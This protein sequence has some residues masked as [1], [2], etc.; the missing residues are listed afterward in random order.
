MKKN[1]YLY[2]DDE[3]NCKTLT[4]GFNDAGIIEVEQLQMERQMTI[5][6]VLSII[7]AC[8]DNFDG[9]IFDLRL[10]GDGANRIEYS[11]STIAQSLRTLCVETGMRDKPF[12]LC[13]TDEKLMGVN[14][15]DSTSRDLY[16]EVFSKNFDIDVEVTSSHLHCLAESYKWLA[17]NSFSPL[18]ILNRTVIEDASLID[19]IEGCT[20]RP[21]AIIRFLLKEL[22]GHPGL[23]I[24]KYILAARLGIDLDKSGQ[25]FNSLSDLLYNDFGYKG[26]L[27][28]YNR[29]FWS[30]DV[31]R[32]FEKASGNR[33]LPMMPAENRVAIVCK[34]TG[35]EGLVSAK[36]IAHDSS[37]LYWSVC[38]ATHQ[39]LDPMEA[40][41]ILEDSSL[42]SWQEPRYISFS[43]LVEHKMDSKVKL[44]SSEKERF[45]LR[46]EEFNAH[47]EDG[48][49]R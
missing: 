10:N 26:V 38:E 8:W 2:I 31:I 7:R 21:N 17:D 37:T 19:A 4:D 28:D 13:S 3:E 14:S 22:F 44:S 33:S 16:D 48:E 20:S 49:E 39:P 23:L 29:Y 9:F 34:T 24:D 45:E 40:F 30:S 1:K 6:S 27:C 42:N 11:A 18:Q 32:W 15:K 46:V 43:S 41:A 12:V 25:A 36:P 47:T 5:D 35:I